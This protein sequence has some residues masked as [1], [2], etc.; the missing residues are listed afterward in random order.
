MNTSA[1]RYA[2]TVA[3]AAAILVG[4]GVGATAISRAGSDPDPTVGTAVK[5]S[6]DSTSSPEPSATPDHELLEVPHSPGVD[7]LDDDSDDRKDDSDHQA[8][9]PSTDSR[10]ALPPSDTQ[11]GVAPGGGDDD[12]YDDESDDESDHEKSDDDHEKSDSEHESESDD[13]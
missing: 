6:D 11:L 7:D 12:A 9:P 13:D 10:V 3:A 1:I 5:L 2:A 8:S 4:V